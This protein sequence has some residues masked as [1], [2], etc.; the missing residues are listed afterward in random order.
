MPSYEAT[1]ETFEAEVLDAH[2]IVLVDFWAPWCGP[3]KMVAPVLEQLSDELSDSVKIV[4]V[5]VDENPNVSR[6]YGIMSIPSLVVFKDG[7]VV[8]KMVGVKNKAYIL[9]ELAEY[10]V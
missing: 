8:N 4:K 3:C 6:Q 7:Q 10:L 5:D 1:D 9:R 2:R